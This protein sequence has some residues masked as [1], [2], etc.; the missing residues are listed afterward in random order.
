[1]SP[2]IAVIIQARMGST[3][4]P[5]K[6]LM[7]LNNRPALWHT[8]ERSRRSKADVVAVATSTV[9]SDDEL[10][11]WCREQGVPVYRGDRDDLIAR[12]R[13]AADAENADVIIRITGDC[14]V[15][16][17]ATIDRVIDTLLASPD[18][19]YA[20]AKAEPQ[21]PDALPRGLNT[22]IFWRKTLDEI[23]RRTPEP[24]HR[25]HVTY[26]VE[27]DPFFVI[28]KAPTPEGLARPDYRLTL[29]TPQDYVMFQRLFGECPVSPETPLAD[30]LHFLDAHPDIRAINAEIEQKPVDD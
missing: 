9:S 3:R 5:G 6:V 1:M 28:A 8:I 4:L 12:Y 23:D 11:T 27:R 10:V 13:L 30:I 17:P 21:Y 14:P 20:H 22:E 29:D 2:R 19:H 16:D 26:I 7:P 25:E 24:R 18:A 15:I